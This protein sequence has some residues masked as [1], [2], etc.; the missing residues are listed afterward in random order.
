MTPIQRGWIQT[1]N[2]R[3]LFGAHKRCNICKQTR[4]ELGHTTTNDK[5]YLP[6][7]NQWINQ[8]QKIT[9]VHLIKI[10]EKYLFPSGFEKKRIRQ[11]NRRWIEENMKTWRF[12]LYGWLAIFPP[13]CGILH[14]HQVHNSAKNPN[15]SAYNK[16]AWFHWI[17]CV[18][19]IVYTTNYSN[20]FVNFSL[21]KAINR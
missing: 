5:S 8:V 13:Q 14:P 4:H 18:L 7:S 10:S 16:T 20:D 11:Q 2:P 19:T 21:M 12:R 15:F 17:Y 6:Q 3:P 9:S 1:A